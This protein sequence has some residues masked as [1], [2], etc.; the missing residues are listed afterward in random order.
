M[1]STSTSRMRLISTSSGASTSLIRLP[2]IS[3]TRTRII[4]IS[5]FLS[6]AGPFD[7]PASPFDFIDQRGNDLL[8]LLIAGL[9]WDAEYFFA[10][11]EGKPVLRRHQDA[12]DVAKTKSSRSTDRRFSE[13][14][15]VGFHHKIVV[16]H[17]ATGANLQGH[18]NGFTSH[19]NTDHS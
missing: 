1:R 2:E 6:L 14:H 3:D 15:A 5:V 10:D 4:P 12:F 7:D 9:R 8:V 17:K 18:E 16:G 11:L 19:H 13:L